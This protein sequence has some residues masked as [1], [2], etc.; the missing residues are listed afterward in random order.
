MTPTTMAASQPTIMTVRQWMAVLRQ[1]KARLDW[2]EQH[3]PE[4]TPNE[5]PDP[6]RPWT[7]KCRGGEWF[8][9]STLREALSDAM[10][11]EAP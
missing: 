10:R 1:D 5:H 7:V 3:K 2:L 9:A 6:A 8:S 4:I 11:K